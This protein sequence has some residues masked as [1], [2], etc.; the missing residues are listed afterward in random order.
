[1]CASKS[2]TEREGERQVSVG[3]AAI[4]LKRLL[5]RA[6]MPAVG[7]SLANLADQLQIAI[8]F[9]RMNYSRATEISGIAVQ[10]PR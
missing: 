5:G 10:G 1:V 3:E 6:F 8:N 4:V 9:S 7:K 2:E